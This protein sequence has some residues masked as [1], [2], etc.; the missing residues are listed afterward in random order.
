MSLRRMLRDL[1]PRRIR[2]ALQLGACG[3]RDLVDMARGREDPLVPPTRLMFDGPRDPRTFRENGQEFLR[4]YIRECG[5]Q[6]SAHVLDVGCGIGRK[7]VPLTG[8]LDAEG[9]YEGIDIVARGVEWCRDHIGA[10]FSNFHFQ[11]VDIW[12]ALYNPRGRTRAAEFTFPFPDGSF[13][14]VVLTSV[15]THMLP[16]DVAR[17]LSEVS[18]VLRPTGRC[19]IS[20]F[21]L[22]GESSRLM[23]EGRSAEQFPH[24][25]GC[26]PVWVRDR[27]V[28]E[29]AVAYDEAFVGGL[30]EHAR[31]VLRQPPLYGAWCGR[32]G[33]TSYQDL[34]VAGRMRA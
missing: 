11:H 17:Y 12:N 28:P 2:G 5:L 21:L 27:A 18:R 33:A 25:H 19:L 4:L 31:L 30:Y 1:I 10:R 13:D 29:E 7:A 9:I 6:P 26:E 8:Y 20:Y 23:A 16:A 15:F 34:L 32:Q 14:F 24:R 3:V 22:N